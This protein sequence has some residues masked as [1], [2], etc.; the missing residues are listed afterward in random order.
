[1]TQETIKPAFIG[2]AKFY[3]PFLPKTIKIGQRLLNLCRHTA[4]M[5]EGHRFWDLQCF[6]VS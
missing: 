5:C 2:L 3:V 4:K 6:K 1:M